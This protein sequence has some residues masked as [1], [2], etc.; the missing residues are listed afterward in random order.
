MVTMS[1][2][3]AAG[4]VAKAQAER[5]AIQANLLDL[6]G[7]FGKR[8][9]TGVELTGVSKRRWESA[10]A[11]LAGL[12]DIYAIYSSVVD[13]AATLAAGKPGQ[14]ELGEITALLTRP[15]VEVTRAPAPL[16][17][18]DLADAGRDRLTLSGAV[19]RMR[20]AFSSVA[21]LV[22]AAEQAWNTVAG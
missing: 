22:A 11:T 18:R 8:L 19:A 14:R 20:A 15:S 21:D 9:L 17:R 6:D 1:R 4:A 16:G 12:W 3:Q 7:S 2:E 5:D 10:A 13:R